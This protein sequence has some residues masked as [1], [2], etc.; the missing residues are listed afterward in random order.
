MGKA[1]GGKEDEVYYP[2]EFSRFLYESAKTEEEKR[3]RDLI[4]RLFFA[5]V[6]STVVVILAI[7]IYQH[8]PN[9]SQFLD[10]ILF[11]FYMIMAVYF[12]LHVCGVFK[13]Y[14]LLKR[15]RKK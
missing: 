10:I 15:I 9:R 6:I 4:V 7:Y 14:F 8:S 12:T 11:P 3:V 13:S 2:S 5:I 1:T